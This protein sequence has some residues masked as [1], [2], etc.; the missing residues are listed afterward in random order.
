M[1][2]SAILTVIPFAVSLAAPEKLPLWPEGAPGAKGQAETDQPRLEIYRPAA[3]R[4]NGAAVVVCPGG[5]YGGLASDHEGI[6]PA[7]FFNNLGVTAYVLFYR[8]GTN[9]YRHPVPLGD[10]QRALRTVRSRAAQDG[11]DAARV[12]IMGFSAGGH[13][14]AT[15]GTHF[16]AGNAAAPDAVERQSSRP[17]WMVLCYPVASFDPAITHAGSVKNLLGEK[18]DDP[19]LLKLLSNERQVTPQTPPAFLFHTTEDKAVPV[20]NSLR[21]YEALKKHD[22][23][24]ELHVYQNGVHG[25]GLMTGDPV[26]GTW[27][28]HLAAWLRDN[29]F[30]CAKV[31]R[32]AVDGTVTI[33]GRPAGWATLCFTPEDPNQPV[34]TARVRNGKF[35]LPAADGPVTGKTRITATLS[36]QDVPGSKSATGF[37]TTTEKVR[38]KGEPL[39]AAIAAGKNVVDLELVW[40]E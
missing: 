34:T 29:G 14:A 17:D 37:L 19:E 13:L 2:L 1:R 21:F 18:A 9:G 38:G 23:P 8:L 24:C 32:A 36:A 4:S 3:E 11:I 35:S 20:E 22:V 30:L 40:S 5:G 31:E 16:D 39:S 15:A 6:Q 10:A 26:L 7:L 33:D 12:G 27:P 25:V 28:R